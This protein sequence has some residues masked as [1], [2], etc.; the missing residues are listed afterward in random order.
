MGGIS[1]L[2]VGFYKHMKQ[3]INAIEVSISILVTQFG[4]S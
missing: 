1:D 2:E 4:H 3:Y